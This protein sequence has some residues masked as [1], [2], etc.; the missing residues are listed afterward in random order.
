MIDNL[1]MI[2]GWAGKSDGNER[3]IAI[4]TTA[5]ARSLVLKVGAERMSLEPAADA[6]AA[7]AIEMPSEAFIRLIYGR[8]DPDHTPAGV[9]GSDVDQL[10]KMFPGF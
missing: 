5:P 10:R 7:G 8:L 3:E 6:A 4:N 2:I 1:G 9:G